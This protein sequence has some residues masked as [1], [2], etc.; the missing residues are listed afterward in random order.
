MAHDQY[1]PNRTSAS[2]SEPSHRTFPKQ[3]SAPITRSHNG[4]K[5]HSRLPSLHSSCRQYI[6]IRAPI[7]HHVYVALSHARFRFYKCNESIKRNPPCHKYGHI[8]ERIMSANVSP[9]LQRS[10]PARRR[11]SSTFCV[12]LTPML[13][14]SRRSCTP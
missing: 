10:C 4:S 5:S 8:D 6:A 1:F 3:A 14:V 2:S 9:N 12:S 7:A 13:R 11:T